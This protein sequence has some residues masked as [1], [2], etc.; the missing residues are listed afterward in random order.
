[1]KFSLL[2]AT[3]AALAPSIT[4]A[5]S[6]DTLSASKE[7]ANR[8]LHTKFTGKQRQSWKSHHK[9]P[10]SKSTK[11]SSGSKTTATADQVDLHVSQ[12][13]GAASAFKTAWHTQ[14]S[15]AWTY[16]QGGAATASA[17]NPS[18]SSSSS[19]SK[20]RTRTRSFPAS[21]S[22]SK[23]TAAPVQT[24]SRAPS[25]TTTTTTKASASATTSAAGSGSTAGAGSIEKIAL[26]AHNTLRKKHSAPDLTW[27]T[28]L[29][30]SAQAWASK[31]VF[32]HGGG[33]ALNSGENL[34]AYYGAS[35]VASGI[36]MWANEAS[37]YDFDNP[38]FSSS[39][40]HF[41]QM[42]WK[43]T[44]QL[45]CAEVKCASLPDPDSGSTMKDYQFLVCHY[46][47][48]GNIV[49]NANKYFIDNVL[50]EST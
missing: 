10:H 25:T 1:M 21:S 47:S 27:S 22:T 7:C 45:G 16:T 30:N 12:A 23:T 38:G 14:W 9:R 13:T 37:N 33:A 50:P 31:C 3:A 17:V 20:R 5:A 43:A 26:D 24:T 49:G 28:D 42:V 40:G 8:R 46:L 19:T 18:S 39:A 48:A 41:T 2:L 11:T 32:K 35:N 6:N 29:A 4:L 15:T 34:A 44:T 36:S